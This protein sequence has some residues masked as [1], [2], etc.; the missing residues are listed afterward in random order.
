MSHQD[1]VLVRTDCHLL[2]NL[3]STRIASRVQPNM[4]PA[5]ESAPV[6]QPPIPHNTSHEDVIATRD[7]LLHLLPLELADKILH[8][9]EYYPRL[10]SVL[11]SHHFEDPLTVSDGRRQVVTSPPIHRPD[12]ISCVLIQTES[13]D[14]GWSSNP[15]DRGRYK[16]SW[17]WLDLGVVRNTSAG[18]AAP[19]WRIYTNI[20]ASNDWQAAE[21]VLDMSNETVAA[22]LPG[23]S[24][25][26][27]AGARCVFHGSLRWI[28][29]F[30][31][32]INK[33]FP[34]GRTMSDQRRSK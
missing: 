12:S 7:V 32:L 15:R 18:V 14:Q 6:A 5:S 28:L 9:A 3:T 19:D 24:L 21:V 1:P 11:P 34:D 20:R 27:W 26:I 23:D 31:L 8:I 29:D 25:V 10:T 17:T 33:G 22:L 30:L 16:N 13:H 4:T 2:T